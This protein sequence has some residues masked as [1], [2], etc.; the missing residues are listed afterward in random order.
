VVEHLADLELV[1]I[2]SAHR[3]YLPWLW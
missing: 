3:I 2:K 1:K